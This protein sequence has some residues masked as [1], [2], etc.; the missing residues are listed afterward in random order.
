MIPQQLAIKVLLLVPSVIL[1]FYAAIYALLSEIKIQPNL[2]KFYRKASFVLLGGG[3]TL[4]I[5]YIMI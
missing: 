5:A 3:V 4:L 2:S 1:I